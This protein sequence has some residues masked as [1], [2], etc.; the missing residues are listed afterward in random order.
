MSARFSSFQYI[1]WTGRVN[2]SHGMHCF[3]FS[4][5]KQPHLTACFNRY[6]SFC[7]DLN[8]S[9]IVTQ[10][11]WRSRFFFVL[12][13]WTEWL[14][15]CSAGRPWSI[16]FIVHLHMK[17]NR[18]WWVTVGVRR[19]WWPAL[20]LLFESYIEVVRCHPELTK[21][22]MTSKMTSFSEKPS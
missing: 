19:T 1:G 4:L 7:N 20:R 2:D 15:C 8:E 11:C 3:T 16:L 5:P 13:T 12:I 21:G 17:L 14:T 22:P 18:F 9:V 10:E 6:I